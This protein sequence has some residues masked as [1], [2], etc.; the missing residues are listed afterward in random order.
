M[1]PEFSESI[2]HDKP[3]TF[4]HETLAL[5]ALEGVVTEIGAQEYAADYIRD[6][7]ISNQ[8]TAGTVTD[9]KRVVVWRLHALDPRPEGGRVQWWMYPSGMKALAGH[10][11]GDKLRAIGPGKKRYSDAV[12][13]VA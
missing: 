2:L 5:V 13:H 9:C 8:R 1:Q 11:G 6:I 7:R 10:R 12:G 4:C 3:K